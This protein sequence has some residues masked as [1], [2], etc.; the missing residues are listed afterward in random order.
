L[1]FPASTF[2][3]VPEPYVPCNETNEI[4]DDDEFHS[5]RPY[6]ASPCDREV[7]ETKLY[8][9]NDLIIKKTFTVTPAT[10][11]CKIG[12][13]GSRTCYYESQETAYVSIG[14]SDAE[15]PIMGNTQLVP[16]SQ[17]GMG[18]LGGNMLGP[19]T[20]MN[21]YVSWYLNGSLYRPE[22]LSLGNWPVSSYSPYTPEQI[23]YLLIDY[24]G[25]LNKLLPWRVQAD[26]RF[27]QIANA[28]LTQEFEVTSFRHNQIV[29]CTAEP[30]ALFPLNPEVQVPCY[31]PAT[32]NLVGEN[33]APALQTLFANLFFSENK[34]RLSEWI[35]YLPPREEDYSNFIDYWRD[36]LRWRGKVCTPHLGV[37]G[38]P[39]YFCIDDPLSDRRLFSYLFPYIPYS[40][41]ENRKGQ[42]IADLSATSQPEINL[43][44]DVEV[45][46]VTF[47][48][49][50]PDYE[51]YPDSD[52]HNLYF[53]HMEEVSDLANLLQKTY[54]PGKK[55]KIPK[56]RSDQDSAAI[57]GETLG[58]LTEKVKFYDTDYCD[59]ENARWNSGD[60]LFGEYHEQAISANEDTD[61]Q[62]SG[63]IRYTAKFTCDFGGAD[64]AELDESRYRNCI[65]QLQGRL[66]GGTPPSQEEIDQCRRQS[67]VDICEKDVYVALSVY[68]R[69]PKADEVWDKLVA[70]E[71]SIYKRL[72]PKGLLEQVELMDLPGVTT[73]RYSS[74]T[75]GVE[76]LAG[77]PS[78]NR[79]GERANIFIPHLGGIYEYFLKGIQKALRPQDFGETI[80]G[81]PHPISQDLAGIA[82]R[83]DV[84]AEVL[85]AIWQIESNG[86][87]SGPCKP[88][89]KGELCGEWDTYELR[90]SYCGPVQIG[91][92]AYY[93][94]TTTD[95]Q[96]PNSPNFLN[97]CE[98]SDA[99]E[100]AARI[101][102]WKK[103]G[104]FNPSDP[105]Y[106][107][108]GIQLEYDSNG[109][110]TLGGDMVYVGNYGG[111]IGCSD[112]ET[113]ERGG[114][115]DIGVIRWGA[116]IT[117]CHGVA[118][119]IDEGHLPPGR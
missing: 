53:S 116:G 107:G 55:P 69:T 50:S 44:N 7:K 64:E 17:E 112:E 5:L 81:F 3:Q 10:G 91:R 34:Y 79:S 101:L 32:K 12:P 78:N 58:V 63:T 72:Y 109:K 113:R 117:Y 36:Y 106:G 23:S 18:D 48:P 35:N 47:E 59:L 42:V 1:V 2:A 51:D 85:E 87:Q 73:A 86:S 46:D 66:P 94:V 98:A 27:Q 62:M 45:T 4:T 100:L 39:I 9:G 70:G 96:N 76:V 11:S 31:E 56:V 40:S 103:Y 71:Q 108:R 25:P 60:D 22:E 29:V 15:L 90:S 54:V 80:S 97:P 21:E 57:G 105:T 33:L 30:G 110:V 118:M 20:R 119:W 114:Y 65:H 37:F 111:T 92:G 6:Q 84:P 14:L 68:T 8:C 82:V 104:R 102:L 99:L 74:T 19:S 16:N 26:A 43:E 77:N 38:L 61:E 49:D 83:Y 115:V 13:D 75:D 67:T 41:T 52:F 93:G 89:K 24:S 28:R 95:E 88:S